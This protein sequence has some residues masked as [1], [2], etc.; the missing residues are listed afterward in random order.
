MKGIHFILPGL[1]MRVDKDINEIFYD[2]GIEILEKDKNYTVIL[3]KMLM[4][5]GFLNYHIVF[6]IVNSAL[7]RCLYPL[8]YIQ[9]R[10][11][12]PHLLKAKI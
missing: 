8:V 6:H 11:I 1:V 10:E 2:F 9:P 5:E 7:H 12:H 4:F 3:H